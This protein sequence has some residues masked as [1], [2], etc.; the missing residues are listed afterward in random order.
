MESLTDIFENRPRQRV[1]S[2]PASERRCTEDPKREE[3]NSS[4]GQPFENVHLATAT[5]PW[6]CLHGQYEL[7]EPINSIG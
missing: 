3:L 1:V 4:Y 2:V 6:I 5:S 7:L